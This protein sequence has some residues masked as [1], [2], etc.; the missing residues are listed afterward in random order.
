[1]NLDE[2]AI[3][4]LRELGIADD[5]LTW[6]AHPDAVRALLKLDPH[7][8]AEQCESCD[9]DAAD[10]HLRTCEV[11]TAWRALGDRRAEEDLLLAEREA[12]EE[13]LRRDRRR[14]REYAPKRMPPSVIVDPRLKDGE[15]YLFQPS[16]FV[17]PPT[18]IFFQDSFSTS[19]AKKPK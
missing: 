11:A 4:R 6:L 8:D 3:D 1:M 10:A 14:S 7:N 18:P 12:R 5:M 13:D 16:D 2:A 17:A 19:G 9:E 15:M